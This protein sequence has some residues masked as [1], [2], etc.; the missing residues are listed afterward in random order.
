MARLVWEFDWEAVRGTEEMVWER[1]LRMLLL[2]AK[3]ELWVRFKP[4]E[5]DADMRR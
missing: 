5:R 1:E 2:W 3:P 4:V